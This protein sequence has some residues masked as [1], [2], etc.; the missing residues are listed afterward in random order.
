MAGS[1]AGALCTCNPRRW[2]TARLTVSTR[3]RHLQESVYRQWIRKGGEFEP[4]GERQQLVPLR[5]A[6]KSHPL[7]HSHR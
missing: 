2:G 7:P 4:E 3:C 6:F 5:E 1:D